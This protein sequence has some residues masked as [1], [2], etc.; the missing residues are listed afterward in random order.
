MGSVSLERPSPDLL[1]TIYL[2]QQRQEW[3]REF[4]RIETVESLNFIGSATLASKT[5]PVAAEIRNILSLNIEERRNLS[6][7]TD[8]LREFVDRADALGVL[9]MISGIVGS[10]P[11]RKLNPIE[12]R[13]FALVDNLAPLI[14]INCA[15]TK[16]AQMFTLAHELAHLWLGETALSNSGLNTQS[17]HPIETWCNRVAAELLVPLDVLRENYRKGE[18]LTIEITRL[19]HRFKVST[20]VI[21][22]RIYDAGELTREQFQ[23]A[24]SSEFEK[25]ATISKRSFGGNFYRTQLS[26]VSKRFAHAIVASTLEGGTSF[27][28][29]FRLLG[30]KKMS[31]FDELARQLGIVR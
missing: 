8:A 28:E 19:A 29:T 20:L 2:C 26:R 23:H 6:S 3:Y 7:W 9:V 12:F 17:V 5:E 21:L 18:E 16:A 1:D 30:I 14:F 10:N 25:V 11:H 31:T 13:G 15:D 4:A 27:T 22:R 24:Y